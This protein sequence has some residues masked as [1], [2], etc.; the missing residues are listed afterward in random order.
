MMGGRVYLDWNASAPLRPEARTKMLSMIDAVGNPSSVHRE[1]RAAKAAVEDARSTIADAFG[2]NPERIVFTSGATEAAA[3]ALAGKSLESSGIEHEAVLAWTRQVLDADGHGRV[4]VHDPESSTLQIANGE[5]GITQSIP[6]GIRVSDATQAIG[7]IPVNSE[8]KKASMVITSA[9]KLGG[10]KGVGALLLRDG[11]DVSPRQPGGGQ[12]LGRRSGTENVVAIA[13]FGAAAKAA[14]KETADGL[15][16]Q[17][18]ELRDLLEDRLMNSIRDLVVIGKGSDRLPNTSCFAVP[19]WKSE[20]QVVQ[21]DLDGFAISAGSAC[22]SGKVR[23][24][25]ALKA[26]GIAS[27]VA[28]SAIRV[29]IGPGTSKSELL[30]FARNWIKRCREHLQRQ[31]QRTTGPVGARAA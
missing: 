25:N 6:E 29:S 30:D 18:G 11:L 24:R 3:L 16:E 31:R 22:S 10:P 1:G 7:K 26:I 20:L 28:G 4:I 19:G 5:T 12:E 27:E 9:H 15:W 2:C 13:G 8:L 21:M 23:S 17:V 14:A